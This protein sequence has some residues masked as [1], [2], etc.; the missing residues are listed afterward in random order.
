MKRPS[1]AV[2]RAVAACVTAAALL[3]GCGVQQTDVIEAGGPATIG[4]FPAPENRM[5][6]FFLSPQGRPTPV[7]RRVGTNLD[8]K[9]GAD[10]PPAGAGPVDRGKVVAALFAGPWA[11]ERE[12]GLHTELPPQLNG[13]VGITATSGKLILRLP[14]AVRPLKAA[15]VRQVVCTVA[16]AGGDGGAEVTIM[17]PD[18]TLPA[19]HC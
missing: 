11:N 12:A 19:A 3:T 16:F 5:V 6:L 13:P 2:G 15:A 10:Y 18:G 17:G 14:L 9:G 8:P 1:T 4:V 7:M